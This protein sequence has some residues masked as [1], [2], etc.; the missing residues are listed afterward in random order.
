M[1]PDCDTLNSSKYYSLQT[2]NSIDQ[3]FF[4]FSLLNFNV[5]S[6]HANGSSFS[7]LIASMNKNPNF[8]VLTETWNKPQTCN[9]CSIEGYSGFHTCRELARSGGVSIFFEKKFSG[10]KI[11]ELSFSNN[12]IEIC[13]CRVHIT[14]GDYLVILGVYR[15]N[16]GTISNFTSILDSLLDSQ[17]LKNAKQIFLAGDININ[18][19]S[20]NDAQTDNYLAMMRSHCLMPVITRPTRFSNDENSTSSSNLDHIWFNG[21]NSFLSGILTIDI[22][23]HCPTFI[24]T[25]MDVGPDTQDKRRIVTRPFSETKLRSLKQ[26]LDE[27]NWDELLFGRPIDIDEACKNFMSKLDMLYCKHFPTKIKYISYKRINNPWLSSQLKKL[28]NKKSSYFKLF[29]LGLISKIENNRM[30]NYVNS[31]VRK[32]KNDYYQRSFNKAKTDMK[33]SWD[34]IRKLLGT[35]SNSS[36]IK[37]LIVDGHEIDHPAEIANCFNNFFCSVAN[38]LESRLPP[39]NHSHSSYLNTPNQHNFYLFDMT[40]EECMKIVSGMKNTSSGPNSMPVKIFKTIA[41][42]ITNPLCKLVNFSF[43]MGLFPNSLKTARIT[44]VFKKGNREELSNY[45]P[46]ASLPFMSKIFER[47]MANKLVAFLRKFSIL[48]PS[49]FGFQKGKSTCDA[50]IHLTNFNYNSLNERKC[51]VNVLIDLRKAFDTVSHHVLIDKL[52]SYGI[53]GTPLNWFR[54]Y[55]RDRRQFVRVGSCDSSI[56]TINIGVPQGSTLGP[57]LFLLFI[58]DLPNASNLLFPT[59]FA[60]DTTLSIARSNFLDLISVLN[61]E[62][63][64]IKEWTVSS[65]LSINVDKTEMILITNKNV[66]NTNIK[67]CSIMKL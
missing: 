8:L 24:L 27:T 12:D 50:L 48:H 47:S 16:T 66:V 63:Q 32:A 31:A 36:D 67:F 30:R 28:L 9:L 40:S 5:R 20:Q 35:K 60:D 2:Y 14:G 41:A 21:L 54:T 38:D 25:R 58:N 26:E 46:I 62:L 15:P 44:P 52:F 57:I 55:L 3:S 34:L 33:K 23:D 10:E 51:A 64:S 17:I 65:R 43:R 4:N 11:D 6:F 1:Y 45:R 7:G 22:T 53:R 42:S 19:S 18:F 39:I 61:Q 59:L 56:N 49:Q 29:K 37:K 13:S